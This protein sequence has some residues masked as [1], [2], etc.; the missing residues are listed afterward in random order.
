MRSMGLDPATLGELFVNKADDSR[1]CQSTT[2]D[3]KQCAR[4]KHPLG[5]THARG[6]ERWEDGAPAYTVVEE[7]PTIS[8]PEGFE[9][10]IPK[11][12]G[13]YINED[14]RD[15]LVT[16]V[17]KALAPVGIAGD[18]M[19]SGQQIAAEIAVDTIIERL[20]GDHE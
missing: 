2:V 5:T 7:G 9:T 1:R 12:S 15:E 10:S 11:I 3:G 18:E 17:S 13:T 4:V 6:Y 14:L 20:A 8:M 16:M 19:K